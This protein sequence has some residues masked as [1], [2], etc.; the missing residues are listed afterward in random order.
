M[1]AILTGVC[2][3]VAMLI[4][5]GIVLL[6][7]RRTRKAKEEAETT[8][9]NQRKIAALERTAEET[10]ELVKVIL[11]TCIILGDGMVQNGIN[12]EFKKAFCKNRQDALKML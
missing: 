1:E 9:E 4:I 8:L 10:R 7:K 6:A 11:S 12:G 3:G 2:V 5:N